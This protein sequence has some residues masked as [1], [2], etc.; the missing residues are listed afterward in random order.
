MNIMLVSVTERTREI[1]IRKAI[2]AR[3]QMI[4]VQFL[5]EALLVSVT[6]CLIGIGLSSLTIF[7]IN[8]VATSLSASMSL[9]VVVIAIAFSMVIGVVFGIYPAYKAA[10]MKPIDALRFDS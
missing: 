10:N 6:G 3:K 4:L 1:G 2:G 9:D 7:I 5:I 8:Q